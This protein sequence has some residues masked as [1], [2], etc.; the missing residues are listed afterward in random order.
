MVFRVLVSSPLGT[1]LELPSASLLA[2]RER[3]IG[4][5]GS[6]AGA[7][8]ANCFAALKGCAAVDGTQDGVYSG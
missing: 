1:A 5:R 4:R 2:W 8:D 7:P 6:A 3:F